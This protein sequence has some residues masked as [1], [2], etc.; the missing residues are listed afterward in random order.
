MYTVGYFFRGHSVDPPS[1]R[2]RNAGIL[3]TIK[4]TTELVADLL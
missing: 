1:V 3:P 2:D 4:D